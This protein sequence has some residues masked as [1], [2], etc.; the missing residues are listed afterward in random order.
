MT[1]IIKTRVFAKTIKFNG[2]DRTVELICAEDAVIT[3]AQ[4]LSILRLRQTI[5]DEAC[6]TEDQAIIKDIVAE[7]KSESL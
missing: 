6:M 5:E 3:D 7:N 1:T 4:I 2:A